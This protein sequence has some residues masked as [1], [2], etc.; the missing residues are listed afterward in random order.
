[1]ERI[2]NQFYIMLRYSKKKEKEKSA[3]VYKLTFIS[4]ISIV[5]EKG[6]VNLILMGISIFNIYIYIYI[7][8]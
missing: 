6:T 7:S 3:F 5:L 2:V 1:M 4:F 8:L